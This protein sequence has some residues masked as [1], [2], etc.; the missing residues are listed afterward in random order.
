MSG[1]N[2]HDSSEKVNE[3]TMFV[4]AGNYNRTRISYSDFFTKHFEFM[5]EKV[6]SVEKPSFLIFAGT[7]IS[8]KPEY[9]VIPTISKS[10]NDAVI[11]R[12]ENCPMCLL[13]DPFLSL[14]HLL[15]RV[16]IT[17]EGSPFVKVLD[18]NTPTA[19]DDETGKT[20]RG[21]TS[22]NIL[23][24]QAGRYTFMMFY[25]EPGSSW[26]ENAGKVWNSMPENRIL[27]F[28]EMD[29]KGKPTEIK[30]NQRLKLVTESHSEVSRVT[31][32]TGPSYVTRIDLSDPRALGF[33]V[34]RS[35][36]VDVSIPLSVKVLSSGILIGRYER[37]ELGLHKL[38]FTNNVSRVHALL[39]HDEMGLWCIDLASTNGTFVDGKKIITHLIKANAL[40]SISDE[41]DL[42]WIFS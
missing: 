8:F 23:F 36:V 33:L 7:N 29:E 22:D 1:D 41:V 42:R 16:C 10:I 34:V 20:V 25:I 19:F 39:L 6:N 35:G 2:T 11:G 5:R 14:R 40:I 31:R 32:I 3:R 30:V 13:E 37:C 24:F 26:G 12:H 21:L 38:P 17:K 27:D 28:T 15:V 9:L 4:V 18:L